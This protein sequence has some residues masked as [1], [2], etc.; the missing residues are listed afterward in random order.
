MVVVTVTIKLTMTTTMKYWM[1]YQ[2]EGNAEETQRE[3]SV[4]RNIEGGKIKDNK[5]AANR[6]HKL[7]PTTQVERNYSGTTYAIRNRFSVGRAI[8]IRY[9]V[10]PERNI[11][12]AMA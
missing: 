7:K 1:R 4:T 6:G 3:K 8:S 10:S 2:E 11:S 12:A 9:R 5:M